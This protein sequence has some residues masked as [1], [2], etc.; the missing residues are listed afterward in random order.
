V[1]ASSQAV[2]GVATWTS[3]SPISQRS[4]YVIFSSDVG[5]FFAGMIPAAGYGSRD[6]STATMQVDY[7]RVWALA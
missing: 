3:T 1:T 5:A 2:D 6:T 7:V 4:E